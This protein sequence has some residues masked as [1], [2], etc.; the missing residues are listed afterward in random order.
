MEEKRKRKLHIDHVESKVKK[1]M[2]E[3]DNDL[4]EREFKKAQKQI[5]HF[6]VKYE[7]EEF[8]EDKVHFYRA[9]DHSLNGYD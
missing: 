6:L 7:N 8:A 1:I 9:L 3:I 5:K 2:D 4:K